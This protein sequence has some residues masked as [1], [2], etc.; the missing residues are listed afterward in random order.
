MT[1]R[2]KP[3]KLQ[4]MVIILIISAVFLV[5]TGFAYWERIGNSLNILTMSSYKAEIVEKYRIPSHV[6]PAES[7]E[8][9]VNVKN[10]GTVDILVR[11]GVKK[12]FGT[13]NGEEFIEDKN[14]DGEMIEIKFASKYWQEGKDGWF[15]YKDILKAGEMTK[16]PL[17]DS[18]RLSEKAGNEYKGKEGHIVVTMESVLAD[19]NGA[20]IW[21]T[22]IKQLGI[23][24]PDAPSGK[25]TIVK[26]CG[27]E[28]GFEIQG[29]G[30]DLFAM[31]KNLT[32]GCSRIQKIEILNSSK[33]NIEIFL[34]AEEIK[35]P[36]I[37]DQQTELIRKL[38]QDHAM[39]ELQEEN[40]VL[41][42]GA[43]GKKFRE[44]GENGKISLGN[45]S[46]GQKKILTV[47]LTL[48][49][50][51]DNRFQSLTAKVKWIFS[52]RGEDGT[53]VKTE[54]PVTGDGTEIENW[55]LCLWAGIT[56][57]T[58]AIWLKGRRRKKKT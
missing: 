14:L 24:W 38:L 7:V 37:S 31:F 39:I 58:V 1:E 18:Y 57:F 46:P 54:V 13:R 26:Y 5:G 47:K 51:M 17:M 19:E 42:S 43:A 44:D 28:E 22:E 52:A 29:D 34:H 8:K 21:G 6:N 16:E 2:K 12:V 50:E 35:Q 27:K 55:I 3:G 9:S 56:V 36:G 33:E 49:P 40:D 11:A 15:Y 32:P 48:S 4:I 53:T 41:Y 25:E 23:V 10:S 20:D 45:F 30:T